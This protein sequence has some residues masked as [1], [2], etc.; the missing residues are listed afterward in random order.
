V[1][2]SKYVIV[3]AVLESPQVGI[4][5]D[6]TLVHARAPPTEGRAVL[7]RS[8][9]RCWQLLMSHE[10]SKRQLDKRAAFMEESMECKNC[11]HAS[12]QG[13]ISNPQIE[14]ILGKCRGLLLIA[15]GDTF[16]T[17]R[18]NMEGSSHNSK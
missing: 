5:F 2:I 13:R 7:E 12:R 4:M 15:L 3:M 16:T 9:R 6:L 14:E 18:G 17:D 8:L 1:R 11:N 10:F